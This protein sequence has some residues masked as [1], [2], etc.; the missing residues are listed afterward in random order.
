MAGAFEVN[1]PKSADGPDGNKVIMSCS[2]TAG[3]PEWRASVRAA[4]AG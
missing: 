1:T 3:I 4:D 2:R